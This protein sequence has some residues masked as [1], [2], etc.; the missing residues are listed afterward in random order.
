MFRV[1][2]N[3]KNDVIPHSKNFDTREECDMWILEMDEKFGVKKAIIQN[4]ETYE[5]EVINF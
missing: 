3:I 4:K 1:A 2:M 5:R